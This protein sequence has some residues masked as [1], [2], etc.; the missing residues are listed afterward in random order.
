MAKRC[1]SFVFLMKSSHLAKKKKN[2]RVSVDLEG[3]SG[4][5]QIIKADNYVSG[6]MGHMFGT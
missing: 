1:L 3:N 6:T 4:F 2:I 5:L